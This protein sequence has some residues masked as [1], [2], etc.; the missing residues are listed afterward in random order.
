MKIIYPI[1]SI[2]SMV[3]FTLGLIYIL[4]EYGMMQATGYLF[5]T[6]GI[7]LFVIHRIEIANLKDGINVA[8][9]EGESK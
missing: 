8:L 4:T 2:I 9:G 5:I 6:M 1:I 7:I 3:S